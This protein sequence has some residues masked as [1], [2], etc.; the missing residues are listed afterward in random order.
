MGL[1][2]VLQIMLKASSFA[3][4][5]AQILAWMGWFCV[6]G[7]GWSIFICTGGACKY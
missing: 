3:L 6:V 2:E 4:P 5:S 7:F 1:R